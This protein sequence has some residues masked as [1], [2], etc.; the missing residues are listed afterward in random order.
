MNKIRQGR[1][2]K[3]NLY[4]MVDPAGTPSDDD[5]PIGF[6]TSVKIAEDIVRLV[7][8]DGVEPRKTFVV[9]AAWQR[10]EELREERLGPGEDDVPKPDD[11]D[12]PS[13]TLS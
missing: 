3:H 9:D 10:A 6:I 8:G 11:E 13:R 12:R 5:L 2:N 4:L 7:N 1:R